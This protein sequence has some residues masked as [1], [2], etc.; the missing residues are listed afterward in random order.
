[1]VN[2]KMYYGEPVNDFASDFLAAETQAM[3]DSI[4]LF[5]NDMK[6]RNIALDVNKLIQTMTLGILTNIRESLENGL[7]DY[8]PDKPEEPV[9][10][11]SEDVVDDN[12]MLVISAKFMRLWVRGIIK[13]ILCT[14]EG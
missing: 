13:A 6:G 8:V 4:K 14:N 10:I 7:L 2:L 5:L 11:N 1:M 9:P 3:R 12:E